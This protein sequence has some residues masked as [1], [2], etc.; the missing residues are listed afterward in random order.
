MLTKEEAQLEKKY[1]IRPS[2][3]PFCRNYCRGMTTAFHNSK[4]LYD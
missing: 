3:K 1:H 4:E 2:N